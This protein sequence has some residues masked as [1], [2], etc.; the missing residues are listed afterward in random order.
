MII[1]AIDIDPQKTFTPICPKELPVVEGNLISAEL[2]NQ[3]SFTNYRILTKDAHPK[4]SV[5]VV[6]SHAEQLKPIRNE[7]NADLTW[8]SHGVPGTLGFEHL[9]DLPQI[10]DYD[11]VVWKGIE[12]NMHPYGACFHDL[13]NELSTGLIEWLKDKQVSII[14]A[15]GLATDF[16]V[17]TTL[18]QLQATGLFTIYLNLAATRGIEVKSTLKAIKEM[19]N[20]GIIVCKSSNQIKDEIFS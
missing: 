15:G 1:A 17:K 6:D 20:N 7:K 16:C 10:M 18:L 13:H 11:Y 19:Q 5:W 2:N 8:V 9:D 4:N 12:P 3:A 14:V